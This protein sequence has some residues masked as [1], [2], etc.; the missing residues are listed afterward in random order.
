MKSQVFFTIT[1]RTFWLF[2]KEKSCSASGNGFRPQN[3]GISCKFFLVS[4]AGRMQ[5]ATSEVIPYKPG[6][7]LCACCALFHC[8]LFDV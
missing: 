4:K 3:D 7:K 5:L 6:N 8:V 2:V 1:V